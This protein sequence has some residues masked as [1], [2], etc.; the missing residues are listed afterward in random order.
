MVILEQR[1]FVLADHAVTE[2]LF[3][4]GINLNLLQFATRFLI[5]INSFFLKKN[6][7]IMYL[8]VSLGDGSAP[9]TCEFGHV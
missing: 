5:L 6:K 9:F 8:T 2:L 3:E 1:Y 4:S 7:S